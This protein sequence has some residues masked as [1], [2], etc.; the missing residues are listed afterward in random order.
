MLVFPLIQEMEPT[1]FWA[2]NW[3]QRAWPRRL[4]NY[5][6]TTVHV[7]KLRGRKDWFR[8]CKSLKSSSFSSLIYEVTKAQ[9]YQNRC[10]RSKTQWVAEL[11]RRPGC[12]EPISG[13]FGLMTHSLSHQNETGNSLT[14]FKPGNYY[15]LV[16]I[17]VL[18]QLTFTPPL[19]PP[20][21]KNPLF[22][23]NTCS[24]K[25][26][27]FYFFCRM[28]LHEGCSEPCTEGLEFCDEA[29]GMVRAGCSEHTI[30]HMKP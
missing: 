10:P 24:L 16:G 1:Q 29:Q 28:H 15:Q 11:D 4:G 21:S 25:N 22:F 6:L 27:G 8:D 30:V 19:F 17:Q 13:S 5:G 3:G 26:P 12:L 2:A 7:R 14:S 9:N 20:L 18:F 23:L